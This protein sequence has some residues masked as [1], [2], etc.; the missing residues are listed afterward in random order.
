MKDRIKDVQKEASLNQTDFADKIGISRSGF[1]KILSGENNP[2]EQTIRA[3]CSEFGINRKW[4]ETG[5]GEMHTSTADSTMIDMLMEGESDFAKS[6]F[7]HFM[8]AWSKLGADQKAAIE[9]AFKVLIEELKKE[10]E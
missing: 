10:D 4:L 9:D 5:K 2:S 3:I 7:A 6:V 1:Q 8:E